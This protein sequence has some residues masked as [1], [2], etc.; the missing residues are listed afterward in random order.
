MC[1]A[2]MEIYYCDK[3]EKVYIKYKIQIM[4]KKSYD[5]N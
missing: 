5:K 2:D 4:F 1:N 3:I